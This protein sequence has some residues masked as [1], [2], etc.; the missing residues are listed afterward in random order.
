MGRLAGPRARLASYPRQCT[1]RGESG[2]LARGFSGPTLPVYELWGGV[3]G[4]AEGEG[5]F[6]VFGGCGAAGRCSGEEVC[7]RLEGDGFFE[8]IEEFLRKW[9][10]RIVVRLSTSTYR[11]LHEISTYSLPHT[12]ECP[13]IPHPSLQ[14]PALCSISFFTR[15]TT[16]YGSSSNCTSSSPWALRQAMPHLYGLPRWTWISRGQI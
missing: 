12:Y 14:S 1:S 3:V 2:T 4:H 10:L 15:T 7:G 16:V 6:R 8:M 13:E 5:A 9:G 11:T